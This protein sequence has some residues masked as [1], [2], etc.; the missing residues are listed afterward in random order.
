MIPHN[1]NYAL[2]EFL[3]IVFDT[4][5]VFILIPMWISLFSRLR[6]AEKSIILLG[7][8]IE[9]MIALEDKRAK[10]LTDDLLVRD[11]EYANF[12]TRNSYYL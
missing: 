9:W 5:I 12:K 10:K 7:K 3:M 8:D 1:Y 4:L 11:D 2:T 6:K